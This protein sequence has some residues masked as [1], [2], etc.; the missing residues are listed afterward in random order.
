MRILIRPYINNLKSFYLDVELTD[1]IRKIKKRIMEK[2]GFKSNSFTDSLGKHTRYIFLLG[3]RELQNGYTLSHYSF[4]INE[5]SY[6]SFGIR[7]T[8]GGPIDNLKNNG[9]IYFN[10]EIVKN[11][12][13]DM[14][15]IKR[16]ELYINLIHYDSNMTN[17]ENYEY[18]NKFKVD[19]VGGFH[20]IDNLTFFRK[21]LQRI[22]KKKIPFIVITS[23]SSGKDIIP[24]CKH[25][26]YIK[27]VIIFCMNYEYN[28]HYIKE[29]PGYVKKV[30]TSINEVY[31]YLKTFEK[32]E[33]NGEIDNNPSY[34]FSYE[35]IKMNR[36]LQQCPVIT[37]QEYDKCYFLVHRAYAHFFGDINSKYL[38]LFN[39][40]NCSII[41]DFLEQINDLD[42][43]EK[44]ELESTFKIL[45]NIEE[46]DIFVEES[47]RAYTYESNFCYLFNR[48]M[49]NIE[50]GLII[51]SYY[52]GP[53]LFGLN[54]YVKRYP[55]FG[56]SKSMTLY[57]NI[58]CPET[59]FYLYKI[60]LKHIICF[61][62]FTSTSSKPIDFKP[63]N[64]AAKINNK[65]KDLIKIKMIFKYN[66]EYGNISPGII[67]ENKRGHD[68]DYISSYPEENEVI[69]FPFT[70]TRI[71]SI[72]SQIINN[73]EIKI[74]NFDII[75]RKTYLEYSLIDNSSEI[76][77]NSKKKKCQIF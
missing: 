22:N 42:K 32:Q 67:V 65:G 26:P 51:L 69:L 35:D 7:Q 23:G 19:V 2:L 3:G 41:I 59:D 20:A 74:I 12:G 30:L 39:R 73:E 52:I 60:N 58:E 33:L 16:D 29:Y 38:N 21:F 13:F 77:N 11:V 31:Q 24:I 40:E 68:G 53:F 50:S 70:F 10:P 54:S 4:Y 15:L 37:S 6:I 71:E 72:Y 55:I 48:I 36:Q 18:Y 45:S 17:S 43:K 61:P 66:H 46:F 75:N 25:Y 5:F 57:R 34:V 28:K 62:S 47:I 1:S 56:F 64:L 63:S 44:D 76:K 8:G 9:N 14:N 49:R 27:E